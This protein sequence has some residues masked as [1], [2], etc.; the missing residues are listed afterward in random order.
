M[1]YML[2]P[3][4]KV[5]KFGREINDLKYREIMTFALNNDLPL[6]RAGK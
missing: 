4:A 3:G 6:S 2:E 5:V 1:Q